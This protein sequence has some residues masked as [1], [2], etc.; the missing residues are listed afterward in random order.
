MSSGTS[1]TGGG[2]FHWRCSVA[3]T[4]GEEVVVRVDVV[5]GNKLWRKCEEEFGHDGDL[6]AQEDGNDGRSG[7][8]EG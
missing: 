1:A 2:I 3:E 6:R 8:N 5:K 7:R 4:H